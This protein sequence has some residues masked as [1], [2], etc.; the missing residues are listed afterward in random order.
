MLYEMRVGSKEGPEGWVF[1]QEAC[2]LFLFLG[3]SRQKSSL[4]VFSMLMVIHKGFCV[5]VFC[6]MP[7]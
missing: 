6:I 2:Q 1:L 7:I 4:R 5:K 3:A